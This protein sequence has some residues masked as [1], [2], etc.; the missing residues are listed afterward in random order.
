LKDRIA[1]FLTHLD[2]FLYARANGDVLDLYHIGGSS[3]VWRYDSIATT[4]DI[5]VLRPKGAANLLQLAE[6]HYGEGTS[7]AEK[8]GFY[9]DVVEPAFPPTPA[10]FE[11]RA[12]QSDGPWKAIRVFQL[13]A[14]DL[15]V[16]K[17][18]RFRPKDRDAIRWLCDRGALDPSTLEERFESAF[19][20]S[21]PKDGDELRDRAFDNL[22]TVQ[23]YLRGE[24]TAI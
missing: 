17:L 24:I 4:Q 7:N 20:W 21:T 19:L 22:K 9:L 3:L 18:S 23:A 8:L 10:G 5:D 11:S 14:H 15:A 6:Q 12:T 16:T 2:T 13:D 1:A